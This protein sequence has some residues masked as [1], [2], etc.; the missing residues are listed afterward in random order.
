MLVFGAPA[1]AAALP[2]ATIDPNPTAGYTTARVSGVIDPGEKAVEAYAEYRVAGSG[3][4]WGERSI[5]NIA[6]NSGP[7]PV[8]GEITGLVPGTEYE[9]RLDAWVGSEFTGYFSPEPNPVLTTKTVDLPTISIEPAGAITPTSVHLSGQIDPNAPE[10]A[11]ASEE[12]EAAFTTTW[13][14]NCTPACPGL[15][16][17]V[18][19]DDSVH[20][21]DAD[22]TGLLPGTDYEATLI[23][24]NAGGEVATETISF[25]TPP[26]APRVTNSFTTRVGS[27][28]AVLAAGIVPGGAPTTYHFEYGSTSAYGQSTAESSSI[29]ADNESHE[30]SATLGSLAPVSTY[31]W[32]VVATNGVASTPGSDHVFTTYPATAPAGGLSDGR[33][34]EQVTPV[35]KYGANA[36]GAVTYVVQAATRGDAISF[37]QQGTFPGAEGAQDFG[38]Y[39]ATRGA[40]GWATQGLLP[41]PTTGVE[42]RLLGQAADLKYAYV[43]NRIPGAGMSLYQRDNRTHQL[44]LIASRV[45]EPA[46]VATSADD[47]KV[48]FECER[49]LTPGAIEEGRN[50]YLWDQGTGTVHLAGVLN[51]ENSEGEAPPAG[52]VAGP[53][54]WA[55]EFGPTFRGGAAIGYYA[56]NALSADG[57]SVYFT[58]LGSGKLYLRTHL[59]APQ[60]MLDGQGECTEPQAACTVEVSASQ[61]AT[62]D[63]EG[64][65]PAAF[66]VASSEGPPVVFFG[67]QGKLT[68]DAT[69]GPGGEGNDLYRYEAETGTLTDLTPDTNPSDPNGAEVQGVLGASADGSRLYFVANGVLGDGAGNGATHGNCVIF[70]LELVQY[71]CN[72]YLWEEGG[73]IKFLTRLSSDPEAASGSTN[74]KVSDQANWIPKPTALIN[75]VSGDQ[76]QARVS[77][78][79]KALVFRSHRQ[80]TDYENNGVPEFYRY[81]VGGGLRCITCAPTGSAPIAAPT[82]FSISGFASPNGPPTTFTTPDFSGDGS[83][84][85]FETAERLVAADTNGDLVCPDVPVFNSGLVVPAC[86][87]VYEWEVSGTGTCTASGPS[88]V[89]SAAGCLYLIST[90]TSPEP[91]FFGGADRKGEDAFFYTSQQLV[92]QDKDDL[93]DIY[94]ARVGGGLAGQNPPPPNPCL[95]RASCQG[96][97]TIAPPSQSAGTAGFSEAQKNPPLKCHKGFKKA[98]RHGKQVCVKQPS[99]KHKA[100]CHKGFKKA[101]RHGKQVCVKQPSHKHK[102]HHHKNGGSK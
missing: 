8:S 61:A 32:R 47:S 95:E 81:R 99:H 7:T 100:K 58:A 45:L 55:D 56:T 70:P 76:R 74:S 77:T 40:E 17:V 89:P 48:L 68:D 16:G 96:P 102:S 24:E 79:G 57:E 36:E 65:K 49:R 39:L 5:E 85:F 98:K 52:A 43:T 87:D 67:S 21:V 29:G 66:Y 91:A 75:Y 30:V 35:D 73:G 15:S 26:V 101:K 33:A 25:S 86:Q 27:T 11:P 82:L 59:L 42:G 51:A 53:Y 20:A 97:S 22:A 44:T 60:S 6:A 4:S 12:V 2:T 83:R 1:A 71:E 94:D 31:H 41:P 72:L 78:D 38:T 37:S 46:I 88:Y 28:E 50:L 93:F 13:H 9:V 62:P 92:G 18:P 10:P 84:F 69:T 19:A 23:G 64:E 54:A 14:F 90:G 34:Y 63:P 80:L 3:S